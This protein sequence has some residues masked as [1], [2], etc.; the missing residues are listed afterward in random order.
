MELSTINYKLELTECNQ[1][2]LIGYEHLVISINQF[3][4]IKTD[5][6]QNGCMQSINILKE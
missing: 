4:V 3:N 5:W 1:Y 6:M 2:D